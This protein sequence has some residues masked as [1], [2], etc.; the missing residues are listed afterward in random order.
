M[1]QFWTNWQRCGRLSCKCMYKWSCTLPVTST[2]FTNFKWY[3]CP[4]ETFSQPLPAPSPILP[5]THSIKSKCTHWVTGPPHML[6]HSLILLC[7][8][9]NLQC[10]CL[11]H[12]FEYS[13]SSSQE[14]SWLFSL[15]SLSLQWLSVLWW[16]PTS[17][18]PL[19]WLC[20]QMIKTQQTCGSIRFLPLIGPT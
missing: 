9:L 12:T 19:F 8:H 2:H 6:R 4:H 20:C 14:P 10:M 5:R 18:N 11:P 16:A 1:P 17:A 3:I 7:L 15:F 13:S